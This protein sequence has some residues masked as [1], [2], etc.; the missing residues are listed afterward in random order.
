[1]RKFLCMIASV[2]RRLKPER[3][4]DREGHYAER[5]RVRRLSLG[6]KALRAAGELALGLRKH[7]AADSATKIAQVI[8]LR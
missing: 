7:V 1:M 3:P 4:S 2:K 5:L 8:A 6:R